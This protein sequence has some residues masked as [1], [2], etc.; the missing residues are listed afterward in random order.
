MNALFFNSVTM[1]KNFKVALNIFFFVQFNMV[2]KV[3][4]T[5]NNN[6]NPQKLLISG[7]VYALFQDRHIKLCNFLSKNM[8]L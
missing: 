2:L 7:H 1:S 3:F 6:S 5:R 4:E 8:Q